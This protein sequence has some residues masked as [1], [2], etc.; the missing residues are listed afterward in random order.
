MDIYESLFSPGSVLN[1]KIARQVFEVLPESGPV[2]AIT[3]RQGH[4]WPSD[5]ERFAKL[6]IGESFLREL[7][8]KIDDGAE[9]VVTTVG[10]CCVIGAQ[11]ATERT[12]CGYV[13][14]ALPQYGPESA[15]ANIDL[16]EIVL[17]QMGLIAKLIE[18]NSQLYE[19]Q[20]KHFN[21]YG[22]PEV[23]TN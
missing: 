13:V 22:Q 4:C 12:N 20:M 8:T 7:Q 6:S 17:N 18:K 1:E 14:I 3:D 15:L 21:T 23:S 2:V 19:L 5:S 9:P 16:I 11:L 10:D